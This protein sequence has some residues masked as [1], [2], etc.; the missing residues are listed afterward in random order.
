SRR[1]PTRT[2]IWSAGLRGSTPRPREG[3]PPR[4]NEPTS[5]HDPDDINI[6]I[7]PNVGVPELWPAV[8]LQEFHLDLT[9]RDAAVTNRRRSGDPRRLPS[10]VATRAS[11]S[12]AFLADPRG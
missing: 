4:T 12:I 2:A 10:I 8:P 1:P 7:R 6:E 5:D 11:R 9:R 3:H